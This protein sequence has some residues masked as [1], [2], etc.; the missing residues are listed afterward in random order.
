MH[1]KKII[2]ILFSIILLVV[3]A[4]QGKHQKRKL[5]D[6]H[7]A[8]GKKL[9]E[10]YPDFIVG[11]N[12]KYITWKDSS[13]FYLS[14]S[15]PTASYQYILENPKICDEFQQKYPKGALKSS[16]EKDFDPGRI[17][18]D[19]FFNKMY[20]AS[21]AEVR[22]NLIEITWC[23]KLARQR[24]KV[25]RINGIDKKIAAISKEL[26]KH[27]EFKPYVTGIGG[28]FNWRKISG[29]DRMSTHSYGTTID[30]NTKYADYWQ[31]NCNC[32]DE[33]ADLQYKNKIPEKIVEIFEKYGFIWGGKWYHYDTM[34]FE[35]RPELL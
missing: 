30:L 29:T 1:G 7:G 13:I 26:D 32:T 28:T 18:F 22:K 16:P 35:Y 6:Y 23:P 8:I 27:P 25:T 24:I 17:R 5:K 11:A 4:L 9:M 33:T 34:H 2:L 21:E 14:E 3:P 15:E 20:G 12:Y 19:S 10:C 31:W